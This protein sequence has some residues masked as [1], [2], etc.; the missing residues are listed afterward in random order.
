MTKLFLF[1]LILSGHLVFAGPKSGADEFENSEV[2]PRS[3]PN[4]VRIP[5]LWTCTNCLWLGGG[6]HY[7]IFQQKAPQNIE[8]VDYRSLGVPSAWAQFRLKLAGRLG[9]TGE[10]QSQ[11]GVDLKTQTLDL[12]DAKVNWTYSTL[13]F[14]YRF[15]N[16]FRLFRHIWIP[17]L[18]FA[19][20]MHSMPFLQKQ[21][22]GGF[23]IV[24]LMF[25]S[26]SLGGYVDILHSEAWHFLLTNR[27]QVPIQSQSRIK[28]QQGLSFDGTIGA[29]YHFNRTVAGAFFWGGQ[30][31]G[32]KYKD[33]L[34]EGNYTLWTSKINLLLGF[35]F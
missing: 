14:D 29:V 5:G 31:H 17:R 27:L 28:V 18:L 8:P 1:I 34:D 20:Q 25:N 26:L 10:Y 35:Y 30:Y 21:D 23:S 12:K 15:K 3:R 19:Y 2:Q 9:L 22:D 7:L 11:S 4:P 24:P 6:A 13:G 32:L 16:N 33:E